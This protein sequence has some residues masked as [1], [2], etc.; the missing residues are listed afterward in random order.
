MLSFD[1]AASLDGL[2]LVPIAAD[3]RAPTPDPDRCGPGWYD[4][5]FDLQRGLEVR[6]V[7]PA[8]QRLGEWIEAF[9][10]S[11]PLVVGSSSGFAMEAP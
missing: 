2:A 10:D 11:R 6:E 1:S 8:E 5:S 7:W 9:L 3:F 4:S